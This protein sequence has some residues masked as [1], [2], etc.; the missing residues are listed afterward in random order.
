M[1]NFIIYILE[2]AVSVSVFYI[3]Y[4]LLLKRDTWFRFN[5]YFLLFGLFFSLIVPLLEFSVSSNVVN[6]SNQFEFNEY[7][8]L[9]AAVSSIEANTIELLPEINYLLLFY[10]M[11]LGI[12]SIRLFNQFIKII[13]T[14]RANETIR[15]GKYK[16]VLLNKAS[17]PFSFFRYIF[18][19]KDD[20]HIGANNLS[21][22][23]TT[24]E[25]I[26]LTKEHTKN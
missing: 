2:S 18:I 6:S 17:T 10:L 26:D 22:E 13:K 21:D 3:F 16:L 1:N 19:D 5:R 23:A 25:G 11:I 24:Y 15:Y 7:L 8:G 12:F 4:E 14:I 20:E 9:S